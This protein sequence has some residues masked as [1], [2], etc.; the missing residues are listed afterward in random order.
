M[1]YKEEL[2][3][4]VKSHSGAFTKEIIIDL[5]DQIENNY[6]ENNLPNEWFVCNFPLQKLNNSERNIDFDIK[7][8]VEGNGSIYVYSLFNPSG[9]VNI[10]IENY[11]KN[12]I[13]DIVRMSN[14]KKIQLFLMNNIK[15]LDHVDSDDVV[16]QRILVP[17]AVPDI[18]NSE[19]LGLKI[20]DKIISIDDNLIVFNGALTHSA[21]N[22]SGDDWIFLSV[23]VL[24]DTKI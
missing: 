17:I 13:N 12:F 15:V 16:S 2:V 8:M 7:E 19:K 9:T 3:N 20:N 5:Y 14:I 22:F 24:E 6:L 23:D 18:S 4:L 10:L 1:P 21:W 11:F